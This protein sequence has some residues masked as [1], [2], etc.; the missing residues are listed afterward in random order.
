VNQSS[1]TDRKDNEIEPVFKR[2]AFNDKIY[3]Y[4][5]TV[6]SRPY[7]R[8]PMRNILR[9][10]VWQINGIEIT[11][12]SIYSDIIIPFSQAVYDVFSIMSGLLWFINNEGIKSIY[13]TLSLSFMHMRIMYYSDY[14]INIHRLSKELKAFSDCTGYSIRYNK[15]IVEHEMFYTVCNIRDTKEDI[16]ITTVL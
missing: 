12:L 10:A 5:P 6:L 13:L 16:V 8:G 14:V 1:A 3:T 4:D 15:T 2:V 7:G 9:E 11:D